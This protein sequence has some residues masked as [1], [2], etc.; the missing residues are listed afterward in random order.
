MRKSQ[1]AKSN[2]RRSARTQSPFSISS[3]MGRT[4]TV[5]RY[6]VLF[7][8]PSNSLKSVICRSVVASCGSVA[9]QIVE[10]IIGVEFF[11]VYVSG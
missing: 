7:P 1:L 11:S 3:R 9:D 4:K 2:N 5:G 6:R 10:L 8:F